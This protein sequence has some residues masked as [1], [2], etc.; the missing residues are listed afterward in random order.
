MQNEL[1]PLLPRL[2]AQIDEDK[3]FKWAVDNVGG[4]T[5]AEAR[6]DFI[7]IFA[8][9]FETATAHWYDVQEMH[10]IYADIPNPKFSGAAVVEHRDPLQ[11]CWIEYF[12]QSII[13]VAQSQEPGSEAR[14]FLYFMLGILRCGW[15]EVIRNLGTV[16]VKKRAG[17]G[18]ETA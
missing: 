9:L 1:Q 5:P 2:Q 7:E 18:K 12:S 15:H 11:S 8:D 4:S 3:D 13:N 10:N 14:D 17:E 16:R 6:A